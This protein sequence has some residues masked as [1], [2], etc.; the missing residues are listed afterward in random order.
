MY[1]ASSR[2]RSRRISSVPMPLVLGEHLQQWDVRA[3]D[4][5]AD[6]G[7]EADYLAVIE[8]QL[9]GVASPEEF[10]VALG[11]WPSRPLS[12]EAAELVGLNPVDGTDE[13]DHAPA[14]LPRR[15]PG[16]Q[17]SAWASVRECAVMG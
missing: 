4:S 2:T 12:K 8:R 11:R 16:G 15:T 7:H 17:T 10:E 5:V 14:R 6:R 3:E 13:F 1:R 9:H